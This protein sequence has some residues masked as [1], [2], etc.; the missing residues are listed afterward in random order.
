MPSL[1]SFTRGRVTGLSLDLSTVS[2]W[3]IELSPT[4][5]FGE[6]G[7]GIMYLYPPA[8]PADRATLFGVA[9]KSLS[10]I[11]ESDRGAIL[12]RIASIGLETGE[13]DK[14]MQRIAEAYSVIKNAPRPPRE[15]LVNEDIERA[16][17]LV[18]GYWKLR[19]WIHEGCKEET[20]M[21]VNFHVLKCIP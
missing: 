3:R 16:K 14:D 1:L 5:V 6:Y 7:L 9:V 19:N 10:E 12:T 20:T 13:L 18:G 11:P 17:E 2:F 15:A 4:M 8:G 21:E